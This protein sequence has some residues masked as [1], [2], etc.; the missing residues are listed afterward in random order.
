[1]TVPEQHHASAALKA[2]IASLGV[3]VPSYTASQS[4]ARDFLLENYSDRLSARSKTVIQKVFGHPSIARRHFA[5]DDPRCLIDEHPDSRI[6][7]FTRQA[8]EISS[9]AVARSLVDAGLKASDVSGLV[10]NTCTGYI[11]PGISTYLIEKLGLPRN[12]AAYDLVGSGCGG[13]IP[14]LQM[15]SALLNGKND[16][17]VVS[18][19]VEIC[20]ATFQMAEDL[21]LIISNALFA[22]GAAACVLRNHPG[23]FSIVA[24]SSRHVPEHRE[25]IRY[26]YKNGQLHNQ[27]SRRLADYVGVTVGGLVD[28]L[29]EAQDIQRKD[30]KYWSLHPGGERVVDA[31]KKV[32]DLSEEQLLPTRRVLADYGNMSSPTVL[33][34]LKEIMKQGIQ[35]GEWCMMVA[36]GAGLSAHACLFKTNAT[37]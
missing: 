30:V 27:L 8:V 36:F 28:D 32:L 34:V 10:V 3:A 20:S 37:P 35:S 19:S 6:G 15:A 22:D 33:F 29:L 4:E 18:V 21:N 12:I 11:C 9:Q 25:A 1:M 5:V 24:S 2:H 26:V 16:S 7:R 17:T 23:V 14:N 13:A 31:V